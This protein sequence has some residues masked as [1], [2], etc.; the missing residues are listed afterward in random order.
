MTNLATQHGLTFEQFEVGDAGESPARTITEAD[1]VTF[2]G[3]SGDY[4]PLHTDAEF[5]KG[6]LFGERVA[7]GLL[8]L[9]VASGL[10]WRTGFLEGTAEALIGVE[11]KFRGPIRI[12]DTIRLRA[13]V[14]KK[15]AMPSL[16]GGFVTFDV[17]LLNQRDEVVQK[18]AWTVLVRGQALDG[19]DA[20]EA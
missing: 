16:G 13:A 19:V 4:N 18:G 14:S 5:A 15:K 6:T 9:S 7:H 10:A 11:W 12:G 2:A 17:T 1:I 20:G 3:L 8:G